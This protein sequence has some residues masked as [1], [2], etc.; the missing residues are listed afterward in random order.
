[1]MANSS[2]LGGYPNTGIRW[3]PKTNN[4]IAACNS[5]GTIKWY[6]REKRNVIAYH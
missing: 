6:N 1:M 3:R 2:R 5:D 4:Q